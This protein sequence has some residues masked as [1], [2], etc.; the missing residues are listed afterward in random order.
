V[1]LVADASTVG[2]RKPKCKFVVV[3]VRSRSEVDGTVPVTVVNSLN[4]RCGCN[5][6]P[7]KVAT[8]QTLDSLSAA[9]NGTE[10]EVDLG[11]VGIGVDVVELAELAGAFSC[12]LLK[13]DLLPLW[14]GS[15]FLPSFI[16][17]YSDVKVKLVEELTQQGRTC[18]S[19]R[20]IG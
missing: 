10:L 19:A 9:L 2:S 3:A 8:I 4:D 12:D 20:C 5:H 13:Q 16:C 7:G 18:S 17:Q 14:T 1:W 6:A 11:G 15:S